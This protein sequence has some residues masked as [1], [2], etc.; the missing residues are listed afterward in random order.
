M[1][2]GVI[3]EMPSKWVGYEKTQI[4]GCS[5]P[6][7]RT[8]CGIFFLIGHIVEPPFSAATVRDQ[9]YAIGTNTVPV[10][11][12]LSTPAFKVF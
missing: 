11:F 3:M 2:E 8:L 1:S 9:S 7:E 6:P 12:P 5:A 4:L 10:C